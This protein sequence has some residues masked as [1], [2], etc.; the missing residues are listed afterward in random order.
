MIAKVIVDVTNSQVDKVFDY[1][2]DESIK[3]GQRVFVPFGNRIIQGFVIGKSDESKVEKNKLKKII[4]AIDDFAC[5]TEEML[6]LM[7]FMVH[8]YHL[9]YI[10]CLRLFIP[11]EM[12][13]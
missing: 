2:V 3:I 12:R 10:D 1:E 11:A 4:S 8:K 9:R 13:T 6:G 7:N 5:I